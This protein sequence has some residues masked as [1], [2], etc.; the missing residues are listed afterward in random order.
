MTWPVAD[1]GIPVVVS[2]MFGHYHQGT[3]ATN[4]LKV[5]I[6]QVKIFANTTIFTK[7]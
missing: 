7:I 3:H 6:V 4:I 5:H 2:W 1:A